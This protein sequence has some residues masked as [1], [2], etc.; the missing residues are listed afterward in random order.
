MPTNTELRAGTTPRGFNVTLHPE[1]LSLEAS[2]TLNARNPLPEFC[3]QI[4]VGNN[5][6]VQQA[7]EKRLKN[8]VEAWCVVK[9]EE[10][11]RKLGEAGVYAAMQYR[12]GKQYYFCA[13]VCV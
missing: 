11:P 1:R 5:V 7:T 8:P 13:L 3:E 10:K 2:H 4:G 9:V 12:K 6:I